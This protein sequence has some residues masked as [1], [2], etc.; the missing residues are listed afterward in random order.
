M[1]CDVHLLLRIR[2]PRLLIYALQIRDGEGNDLVWYDLV[3]TYGHMESVFRN[4][5]SESMMEEG[6]FSLQSMGN[7]YTSQ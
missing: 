2:G 4:L 1:Y 5:L 7:I 3:I 6:D